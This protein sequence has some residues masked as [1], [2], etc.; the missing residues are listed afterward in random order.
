MCPIYEIE[1]GN[2]W[3]TELEGEDSSVGDG[4]LASIAACAKIQTHLAK[5]LLGEGNLRAARFHLSKARGRFTSV[6][7][8]ESLARRAVGVLMK[9]GNMRIGFVAYREP[10]DYKEANMG[11]DF[12]ELGLRGK[13]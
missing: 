9:G 8:P 6:G 5:K 1:S 2:A 10:V 11:R 7:M 12:R 13:R 3:I 4:C